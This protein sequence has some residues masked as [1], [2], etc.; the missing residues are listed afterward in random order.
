MDNT[1][2]PWVVVESGSILVGTNDRSILFGGTGPR[3]EVNIDY[4]FRISELPLDFKEAVRIVEDTEMELVSE[5]EWQLAYSRGLISGIDGTSELLADAAQD[6]W[7][8]PCDG[9]PFV[10]DRNSPQII[11]RWKSGLADSLTVFTHRESAKPEYGR[12]RLVIREHSGWSSN[13]SIIPE[14]RNTTSIFMEEVLICLFVGV[15]PSF[16]WA[17]FNA[18]PEYI[19]EGWLNLILG[20]I[21]F[22]IFTMLFWRPKQPTWY[23][24]SGQMIPRKG[25]NK[26]N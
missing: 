12:I 4:S 25:E 18:S 6:F 26:P 2:I 10:K 5:S 3:H 21:F 7:G 16:V 22:S 23:Y 11:R 13:P 1:Q 17:S 24:E 9:R 15:F 20:G 14:K 8:K 19:Y